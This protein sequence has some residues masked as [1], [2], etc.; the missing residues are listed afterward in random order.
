MQ[1]IMKHST[2]IAA[3]LLGALLCGAGPRTGRAA[4]YE[5]YHENVMGTSLELRVR[6]VEEPAARWAEDQVL[7]EIDRQS[8]IFSGYDPA[9]EFRRWQSA[10]PQP[11]RVS[12]ELFAV[13][14]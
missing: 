12:P 6:A 7:R 3:Y 1:P 4:D 9:S 14:S 10:A 2:R 5:F 13:L 11:V 8:A